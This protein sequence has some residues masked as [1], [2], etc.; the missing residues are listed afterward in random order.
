MPGDVLLG[1]GL[2]SEGVVAWRTT[3]EARV[4]TVLFRARDGDPRVNATLSRL[5]L[6]VTENVGERT[7]PAVRIPPDPDPLRGMATEFTLKPLRSIGCD[8]FTVSRVL[9]SLQ[10]A[11]RINRKKSTFRHPSAIFLPDE[12][13]TSEETRLRRGRKPQKKH[14]LNQS[15]CI[16]VSPY[17]SL[18]DS[19]EPLPASE[20]ERGT[21]PRT[22]TVVR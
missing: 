5:R 22:P 2:M 16:D 18:L 10:N 15:F 3:H 13:D 17:L 8:V 12:T 20:D 19:L 9:A 1:T 7:L 6:I 11:G 4:V 21:A 14:L